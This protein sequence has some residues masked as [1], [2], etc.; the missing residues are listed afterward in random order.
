MKFLEQEMAL[1]KRLRELG[2]PWEPPIGNYVWDAKN[3]CKRWT[4]VDRLGENVL[5][6][7]LELH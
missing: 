5:R 6:H 3:F 7:Y 2:L 4:T 1:A